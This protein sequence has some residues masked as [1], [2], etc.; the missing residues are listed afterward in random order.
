[1]VMMASAASAQPAALEVDPYLTNVSRFESWSFFEP[2]P[3]GGD[4]TYTLLGNRATLGVRVKGVRFDLDGAFEYGQ[5]ANLPAR[6]N[7]PGALGPGALYFEAARTPAAYQLYFRTLSLRV[8][9]VIAGLSIEV[10]RMHY[11]SGDGQSGV[12]ARLIGGFEWS[13]FQRAF[14]GARVDVERT[15]WRAHAALL[16]PTQGGF[17]ES[18]NPTLSKLRLITVEGAVSPVHGFVYHYRDRR[19][20]TARPDNTG[21]TA[22]NTDIDITTVGGSHVGTYSTGSGE[23]GSTVWVAVQRGNWFG[24]THR[25]FSVASE[26]GH[27]WRSWWQPL[28]RAGFLYASGDDD[29]A[30]YKHGTFFQMVPSAQRYARSLTYAQMNVRDAFVRVHLQPRDYLGVDAEVHRV[31]LAHDADRWYA[32]SGATAGAGTFFGYTD[33]LSFDASGLGTIIE[34]SADAKFSKRWSVQGYLGLMRG[35]EVVRRSFAGDHL[36]FFYL[37]NVLRF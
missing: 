7:G 26:V 21:L 3:A 12:E 34:V 31:S 23:I 37:Q 35:G 22:T 6:A 1:M 13:M 19:D 5:L 33:R 30:D 11:T 24:D 9:N 28:V 36:R 18:A 27:T 32:G 8:K 10:G 4:P 15:R 17:E 16:F 29:P 2:P 14:D 25:A 20:V